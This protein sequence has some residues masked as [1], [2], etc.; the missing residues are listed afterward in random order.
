[1]TQGISQRLD[2]EI[3]MREYV[4]GFV[5][6]AALVITA[7]AMGSWSAPVSALKQTDLH[8]CVLWSASMTIDGELVTAFWIDC[9]EGCFQVV[10]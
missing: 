6:S 5:M 4:K 1:V 3:D 10:G 9:D 8:N 7:A 2:G